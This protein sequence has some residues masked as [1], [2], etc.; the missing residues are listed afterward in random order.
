ML[1]A[2]RSSAA[3]AVSRWLVMSQCSLS[4]LADARYGIIHNMNE[5]DSGMRGGNDCTRAKVS[6]DDRLLKIRANA[7][8]EVRGIC[9]SCS[10]RSFM[11]LG[12]VANDERPLEDIPRI[13]D[14]ER[15][16]RDG[17]DS[18][19]VSLNALAGKLHRWRCWRDGRTVN[20]L[21][22]KVS[23]A[24]VESGKHS[25][26][27]V[28][29]FD[30]PR[31]CSKNTISWLAWSSKLVDKRQSFEDVDVIA[32]CVVKADGSISQF[33]SFNLERVDSA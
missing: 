6:R 24:N 30:Q 12:L 33:M 21:A 17:R 10:F 9:R 14:R 20:V 15:L 28:V 13:L 3:L 19:F 5:S 18:R 31:C 4:R 11:L 29:N 8:R 27:K 23:G 1:L 26:D 2:R 22:S 7:G 25:I 32:C 16:C